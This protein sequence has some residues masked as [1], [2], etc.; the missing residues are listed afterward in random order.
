M[1]RKEIQKL[2]FGIIVLVLIAIFP[3]KVLI[4][5]NNTNLKLLS[6]GIILTIVLGGYNM[7]KSIFKN[8]VVEELKAANRLAKEQLDIEKAKMKEEERKRPY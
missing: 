5:E 1:E 3:S 4:M 6:I 7:F 2:V 8:P